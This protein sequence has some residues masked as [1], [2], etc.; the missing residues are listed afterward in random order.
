MI[1]VDESALRKRV[2]LFYVA[3]GLNLGMGFFVLTAGA[4]AAPRGT[5]WMIALVFLVFALL[6]FY[7][8][9]TLRRRWAEMARQQRKDAL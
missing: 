9:R 5:L 6:N 2:L 4:G 8:A 1:Q 7:V 3:A